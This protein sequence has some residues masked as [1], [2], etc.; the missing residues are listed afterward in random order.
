MRWL[1]LR[2][3][4][5]LKSIADSGTF[6]AF[7]TMDKNLP[8]QQKIKGLPFA[9][10]VLRA[11]SN[12]FEDTQSLMSELLRRLPESRPGQALIIALPD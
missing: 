11:R 8:H 5:L 6:D 7:V 10:V 12:R 4:Q 2:N 1:G 3:G 9:I